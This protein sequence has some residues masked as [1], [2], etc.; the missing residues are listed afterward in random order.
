MAISQSGFGHSFDI[1]VTLWG[2][3]SGADQDGLLRTLRDGNLELSSDNKLKANTSQKFVFEI[4]LTG[5]VTIVR[6]ITGPSQ[7]Y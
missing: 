4:Y 7:K 1:M 3:P 5:F 6:L 2:T